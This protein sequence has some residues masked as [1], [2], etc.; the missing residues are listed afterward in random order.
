[1]CKLRICREDALHLV[2]IPLFDSVVW[3]S[4]KSEDYQDW[5]AILLI[6]QKFL[7]Y[8]SKGK[9]LIEKLL[10]QMNNYRLSTSGIPR[11]N[12]ALL[13]SEVADLLKEPANAELR[14][15]KIWIKSENRFLKRPSAFQK[16]LLKGDF[17]LPAT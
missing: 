13:L 17:D 16:S 10:A 7:H 11:V 6:K 8:T 3:R 5:K 12:R 4:K 1:V 9:D 2:I 15:G 14:D